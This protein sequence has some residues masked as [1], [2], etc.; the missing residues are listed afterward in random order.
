MDLTFLW[1]RP[2]FD[3]LLFRKCVQV[4]GRDVAYEIV[5]KFCGN[6]VENMP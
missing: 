6:V 1:R 5:R 3:D 4:V 2:I